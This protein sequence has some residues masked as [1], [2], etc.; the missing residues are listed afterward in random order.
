[1]LLAGA[2][3]LQLVT[4]AHLLEAGV[5]VVEV[6]EAAR[7]KPNLEGALAMWGQWGRIREGAASLARLARSGVPY[8]TGWGI[9]SAE[10]ARN[11]QG[12]G[13]AVVTRLDSEWRPVP[14][15]ERSVVCDTIC[16]GYGFIPLNGLSRLAGA[17]Q[18]W[19]DAL[20][21]E[22]PCR[23]AQF[24]TSVPGIFVAGDGASVGGYRL[25][26][27]EGATAGGYAA[28]ASGSPGTRPRGTRMLEIADARA[29]RLAPALRQEQRFQ[30][31]YARLFIPRAGL[32]EL[33]R[34]DTLVCR[35]EGV[36]LAAITAAVQAGAVTSGEV[37]AATRCGMG[38]CQGR[39]CGPQVAHILARLTGMPPAAV[40]VNPARP[41]LFP[42]AVEEFVG[43]ID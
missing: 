10:P 8:Q 23:D 15:S 40:G 22:I 27:L 16:T 41:P 7:L 42:I 26:M 5:A 25:A 1:V 2:G 4:A 30:Q 29:A 12:V 13:G 3:P 21:G 19:R 33:A 43:E 35:C 24:Q 39:I 17:A 38:E 37:K 20:G 9:L 6:L 32:Y 14:G 18:V 11:G 31:L 34:P 28:A 36:P